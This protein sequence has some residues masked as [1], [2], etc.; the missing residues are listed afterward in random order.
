MSA[1]EKIQEKSIVSVFKRSAKKSPFYKRY[2]EHWGI[3]AS[4]I[5]NLESFKSKVPTL[6]KD[7][8][9]MSN[10]LNI[11]DICVDGNFKGCEFIFPSS[12]YS[13]KFSFGLVLKGAAPT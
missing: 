3:D 1:L 13:G 6:D 7:K 9:F 5:K 8:L 11:N 2:L 10:R 12:G 4:Q